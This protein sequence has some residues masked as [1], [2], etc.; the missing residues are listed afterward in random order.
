MDDSDLFVFTLRW[1]EHSDASVPCGPQ[2]LRHRKSLRGGVSNRRRAPYGVA[3]PGAREPGSGELAGGSD[4]PSQRP[5]HSLNL[6]FSWA[7]AVLPETQYPPR[8]WSSALARGCVQTLR[9]ARD[10]RVGS[11]GNP[12][13]PPDQGQV[14]TQ[15]GPGG[16]RV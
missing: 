7:A 2:F 12:R 6:H 13:P 3:A 16:P 15:A 9:P 4:G 11:W 14:L 1:N 5:P 10:T 8:A